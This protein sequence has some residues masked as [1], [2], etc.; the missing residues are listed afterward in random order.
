MTKMRISNALLFAC[1]TFYASP[2]HSEPASVCAALFEKAE[3]EQELISNDTAG[4]G[5]VGNGTSTP[6]RMSS[7]NL[8]TYLS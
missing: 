8:K 4:R 1:S 7:A 5:V 3:Q 2:G 6:R